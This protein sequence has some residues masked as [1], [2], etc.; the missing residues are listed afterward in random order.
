MRHR[1]P[2][3]RAPL[4]P[5]QLLGQPL[6]LPIRGWTPVWIRRSMAARARSNRATAAR[7]IAA[8]VPA[9][10]KT[11]RLCA[12]SACT[13]SSLAPAETTAA[14]H[15]DNTS[16]RRPSLTLATHSLSAIWRNQPGTA[17]A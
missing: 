14:S 8:G 4:G 3:V 17:L 5:G 12:P 10:V 13:C 7:S 2:E 11:L 15:A 16:R 6:E 9:K 1:R